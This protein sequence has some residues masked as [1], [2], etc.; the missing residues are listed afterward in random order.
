MYYCFKCREIYDITWE[1]LETDRSN[2]EWDRIRRRCPKKHCSGYVHNIDDD[3]VPVIDAVL[4]WFDQS[5]VDDTIPFI[6][7]TLHSCSGHWDEEVHDGHPSLPY[8]VICVLPKGMN[9]SDMEYFS[10]DENR[11]KYYQSM[12][13]FI[14]GGV[15]PEYADISISPITVMWNKFDDINGDPHSA[16]EGWIPITIGIDALW[17]E[18]NMPSVGKPLTAK[19]DAMRRHSKYIDMFIEVLVSLKDRLMELWS[20]KLPGED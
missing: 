12:E 5:N 13:E 16:D 20:E 3:I 8:L 17:V 11:Q 9:L 7:M 10:A 4:D 19:I 1:N 18:E 6:G 14:D 2:H 15:Y